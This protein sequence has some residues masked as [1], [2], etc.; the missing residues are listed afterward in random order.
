MPDK[1]GPGPGE[2]VLAI[3]RQASH[4]Y[5]LDERIEAGVVLT[6]TEVKSAR[7]GQVQLRDSHA[8]VKD[9]EVWLLQCH[10]I[11]YAQ[12]NLFN[13]EPT[14]TRKLL[15]R[16]EQIRRLIGKVRERGLTLIPT[17]LYLKNGRIKVEVA[18]AKGKRDYD[19]RETE[20][21]READKEARLAMRQRKQN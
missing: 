2:K 18:V 17:R 14:R 12:G 4:N 7:G 13:H 5:Y 8:I 19:K 16:K 21:R 15:L 10:I 6:G 3:N 20:R 1:K 11:P 9:G